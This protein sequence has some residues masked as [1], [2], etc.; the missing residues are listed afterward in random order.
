MEIKRKVTR[1]EVVK[2]TNLVKCLKGT[3]RAPLRRAEFKFSHRAKLYFV[4]GKIW[5]IR[6]NT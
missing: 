3:Y 1:C 6:R 2:R 5:A 4:W